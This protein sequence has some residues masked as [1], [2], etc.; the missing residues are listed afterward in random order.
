MTEY[1]WDGPPDHGEAIT[2]PPDDFINLVRDA[3]TH[4]YDFAHLE[5][6]P[7]VRCL[8]SRDAGSGRALRN[9]LIDTIEKLQPESG[10]PGRDRAWRPYNI[11]MR[12]YVDGFEIE[13]IITDMHISLRQY[14]RDH[15]KGLR[16]ISELLWR[17]W[18][19]SEGDIAAANVPLPDAAPEAQM[20]SEVARLGVDRRKLDL[21]GVITSVIESARSLARSHSIAIDTRSPGEPIVVWADPALAR[22][23]SLS[24]VSALI[25]AHP[26]RLEIAW[27]SRG[28]L[29]IL[30]IRPT[31][32]LENDG[33]TSALGMARRLWDHSL[34]DRR[35]TAGP[36]PNAALTPAADEEAARIARQSGR[37]PLRVHDLV[38][39]IEQTLRPLAQ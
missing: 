23:A 5:C 2:V 12:R 27:G 34:P 33:S 32:S 19:R 18:A 13:A 11:L 29:G 39:R 37:G 36:L 26:Q 17:H 4:L 35:P 10:V 7:L 3:L 6:H 15:R 8:S 20:L 21:G 24:A 14:H 9:L 38:E 28:D 25:G 22:Q 16:A 1:E 30:D 31:P